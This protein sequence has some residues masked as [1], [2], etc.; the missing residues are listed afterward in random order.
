MKNPEQISSL[1]GNNRTLSLRSGTRQ[2]RPLSPLLFSIVL[3]SIAIR[4]QKEIKAIK[5]SKEEV[6][7]HYLL[8]T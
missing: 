7:F 6:E 3:N 2:G 1:M 8:M 5:I 4:Q